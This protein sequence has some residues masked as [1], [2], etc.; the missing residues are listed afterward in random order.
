MKKENGIK[1]ETGEIAVYV[2]EIETQ[3]KGS[4]GI[5]SAS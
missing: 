3:E 4:S 5:S 2:G 1:R